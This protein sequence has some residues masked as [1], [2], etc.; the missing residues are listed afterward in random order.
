MDVKSAFA[1]NVGISDPQT[2]RKIRLAARREYLLFLIG[3]FQY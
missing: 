1:G 2:P 3:G